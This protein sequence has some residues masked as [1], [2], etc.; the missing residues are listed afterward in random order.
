MESYRFP[1][2]ISILVMGDSHIQSAICDSVINNARNIAQTNESFIYTFYKIKY[3]TKNNPQI[4]TIFLGSG[5]HSFSG[6]YNY[7]VFN[8]SVSANYFWILPPKDQVVI[9]NGIEDPLRFLADNIWTEIKHRFYPPHDTLWLGSWKNINPK[10]SITDSSIRKR[11]Q[12]QFFQNDKYWE[13]SNLN[14]TWFNKIVKYCNDRHISLVILNTPMHES[15]KK[16]V[17][18][19]FTSQYYL[20]MN[21]NRIPLYEFSEL[22]LKEDDFLPDGDHLS[23]KGSLH[24]S[25]SLNAWI[26]GSYEKPANTSPASSGNMIKQPKPLSIN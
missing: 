1:P 8:P 17:P 15:Y 11:I 13:F 16:R 25:H 14:I 4:D 23:T 10:F 26:L 3:L 2:N 6:Y 12:D 18:E 5:Y 20:L 22:F 7:Y 24:A 9:L 21:Q 19:K